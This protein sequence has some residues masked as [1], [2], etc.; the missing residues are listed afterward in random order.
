VRKPT[1]SL[2][3]LVAALTSGA[4]AFAQRPALMPDDPAREPPVVAPAQPVGAAPSPPSSDV[5][6]P[7]GTPAEPPSPPAPVRVWYGYQTAVCDVVSI[8]VFAVGLDLARSSSTSLLGISLGAASGFGYVLAAPI[9]HFAHDRDRVAVGDI[10]LRAGLPFFSALRGT[11]LTL[12]FNSLAP[13]LIGIGVGF[14]APMVADATVIAWETRPPP[15]SVV[16]APPVS[17]VPV[18]RIV[19]GEQDR[20]GTVTGVA[21]TF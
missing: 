20:V 2:G 4:P 10:A 16:A 5:E 15:A 12:K 13:E 6:G 3:V 1:L 9:V 14:A 8:A 7:A 17:L 18:L 21:G 11:L 19:R